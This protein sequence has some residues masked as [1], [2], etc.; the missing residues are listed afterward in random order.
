MKKSTQAGARNLTLPIDFDNGRLSSLPLPEWI[1][2][3]LGGAMMRYDQ[4]DGKPR[5]YGVREWVHWVSGSKSR[6]ASSAWSKLKTKLFQEDEEIKVSL[7]WIPLRIP[8]S[9]GMQMVDLADAQGLYQITMRMTDRSSVVRGVK[10]YLAKSG[11]I[12]DTQRLKDSPLSMMSVSSPLSGIRKRAMEQE[13][14]SRIHMMEALEAAVYFI[15]QGWQFQEAADTVLIAL[16]S[17]TLKNLK[18]ELG[19]GSLDLLQQHQP[20]VAVSYQT[21]AQEMAA[22]E[23]EDRAELSWEEAR[24]FIYKAAKFIG[25]QVEETSRIFKID[26]A[27]GR[28]LLVDQTSQ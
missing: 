18:A 11:V 20:I 17:R 9:G 10:E 23:L 12:V 27:T 16:Y 6:N 13:H 8:T 1:I 15:V 7:F 5:L 22:K 2:D 26:V 21:I 3:R 24:D 19:L 25:K 4:P 28:P 14:V